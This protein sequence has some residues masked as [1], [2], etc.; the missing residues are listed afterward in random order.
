M[1]EQFDPKEH[2]N[3]GTPECCGECDN[4]KDWYLISINP[5]YKMFFNPRTGERKKQEYKK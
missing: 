1:A 5:W 3:C 4:P 2:V